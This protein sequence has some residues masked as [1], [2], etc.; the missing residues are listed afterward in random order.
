MSTL[1]DNVTFGRRKDREKGEKYL[2][3]VGLGKEMKTRADKA[4][5]GMKQRT[6]FARMMLAAE[7]AD[8]VL[9]DEPF[10]AQDEVNLNIM[11]NIVEELAKTKRVV[12]V[13]HV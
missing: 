7:N 6:S 2:T 3:A 5:G 13:S 9:L 8:I 10:S 12:L 4:S 11:K 1:L